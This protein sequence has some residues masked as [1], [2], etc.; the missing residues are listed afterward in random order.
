MDDPA[1]PRVPAV[2]VNEV[3]SHPAPGQS[4]AVELF[5]P[6]TTPADVS[7]WFLTDDFHTP[8]KFRL[9]PGSVIAPG[10]FLVVGKQLLEAGSGISF[11]I[12]A[13]GD[14]LYLFSSDGVNLTGYVHGF[15]FGAAAEGVSFGRYVTSLGEERFVAQERTT[16]GSANATTRVGPIVINEIMFDPPLLGTNN[17]ILDEYVELLNITT[18]P[19]PLLETAIPTYPWRLTGGAT[20]HFPTNLTLGA[21]ESLLVVN[22]DPTN[23]IVLADFRAKYAV[24][25]NVPV[26]GPYHGNLSNDGERLSLARPVLID[27]STNDVETVGYVLV[28]EVRYAAVPPW[29]PG[30]QGTGQSLQRISPAAYGDDPANWLAAPPTAGASTAA[31]AIDSDRD[32]LPDAWEFS[33]FGDLNPGP[34]DDPDDDGFTNAQEFVAGTDP[35]NPASLPLIQWVAAAHGK[36]QLSFHAIARRSYSILSADQLAGP[37]R[38]LLELPAQSET[39]DLTVPVEP[40]GHTQFYRLAAQYPGR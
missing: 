2:L 17:N 34:T 5:N 3:L 8:K 14:D 10:G 18:Q 23:Q 38:T 9:S 40:P 15:S 31:S 25:T 37:W 16:L 26:V 1:S 4:D 27:G 35:R 24:P 32:G 19:I 7:G 13:A 29:P 12:S 11:A 39:A 28:D 6:G 21:A 30:A 33:H 36:A 20:F 22:F